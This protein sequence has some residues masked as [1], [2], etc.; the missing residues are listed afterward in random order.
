[1]A[2]RLIRCCVT[3]V[4]RSLDTLEKFAVS[5]SCFDHVS[6]LTTTAFGSDV[7]VTLS[8]ATHVQLYDAE[9]LNCRVSYDVSAGKLLSV[10][11]KVT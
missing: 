7:W 1:M 9:T 8:G 6:S 5:G 11:Q 10:G 4:V 2:A 3:F